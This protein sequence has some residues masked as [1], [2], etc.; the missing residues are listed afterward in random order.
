VVQLVLTSMVV[1]MRLLLASVS[2]TLM[3]RLV[4]FII[5]VLLEYQIPI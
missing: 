3:S 5:R 1:M 2:E 4:E